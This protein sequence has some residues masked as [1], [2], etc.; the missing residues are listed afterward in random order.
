[1]SF[2]R[3]EPFFPRAMV[4]GSRYTGQVGTTSTL[5]GFTGST[6][7]EFQLPIWVPNAVTLNR[8]GL[9][10]SNAGGVGCVWRLGIRSSTGVDGKPSSLVLDAGAGIDG[11]LV[12]YQEI[13]INQRLGNGLYY[14]CAAQQ[15]AAGPGAGIRYVVNS[16]ILSNLVTGA[17]IPA[18][19]YLSGN[20][21]GALPTLPNGD[22]VV[23][24]NANTPFITVR[25]V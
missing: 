7:T 19:G 23:Q 18:S 21:S 14:L 25:V 1:M 17:G 10:I 12:A 2:T 22:G 11:T 4:S 24:P 16:N 9:V 5:A 6:T 15:V 13:V 3:V 20:A 8:I